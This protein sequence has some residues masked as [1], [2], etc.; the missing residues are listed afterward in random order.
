MNQEKILDVA[1]EVQNSLFSK[2]ILSATTHIILVLILWKITPIV[3]EDFNINFYSMAIIGL[4]A[5]RIL[6]AQSVRFLNAT[7]QKI[8][9]NILRS[10]VIVTGL[11]WGLIGYFG[12]ANYG[13]TLD[14]IILLIPIAGVAAGANSSLFYEPTVL[15]LFTILSIAPAIIAEVVS[16]N[17]TAYG[18]A[19]MTTL[20]LAFL[21]IQCE[22]N[23]ST[24][25]KSLHLRNKNVVEKNKL[26][27]L[28]AAIPGYISWINLDGKYLGVN[29][30]L[31]ELFGKKAEDFVGMDVGSFQNDK[32]FKDIINNFTQSDKSVET[33]EVLLKTPM[34]E[35]WML[36]ALKRY[37]SFNKEEIVVI[38]I[39]SHDKKTAERELES[40]RAS[41]LNSSKLASLG[42]MA[43]NFAHEI[44][45]PLAIISGKSNRIR[46]T[47]ANFKEHDFSAAIK[48]LD[49]IDS[50]L[51]R[52][53]KIIKGLRNMSRDGSA[54]QAEKTLVKNI[55]DETIEMSRSKF[56][57][58]MVEIRVSDYNQNLEIFCRPV[59]IGQ[60]IINLLAN[61]V[62]AV[63]ELPEKW[64]ELSVLD[65]PTETQIRITDSGKGIPLEVQ[66][67]LMQPF[68]TTKPVGKGTGLGLNISR[69]ILENHGGQFYL[70]NNSPNTCFVLSLPKLAK[71]NSDAA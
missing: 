52:I 65:S 63:E 23:C 46:K 43:G 68:F 20:F 61:A 28:L 50:T 56:R 48:D 51:I 5:L 13:I 66:E 55:I 57:N 42:Q 30:Q 37:G 34:G 54:D 9:S 17:S 53:T 35:R 6:T 19:A 27:A 60:V 15:K 11:C 12:I 47:L 33:H 4:A 67:K 70:D 21:L 59:Q 18:V 2:S 69:K 10:F 22:K 71:I 32:I 3:T 24:A 36:L 44:N 49:S 64:V 7:H 39:D 41:S 25:L 1:E 16:K 58:S 31:A 45:N 26:S 14:S 38:G 62:D 40:A 29:P 8:A